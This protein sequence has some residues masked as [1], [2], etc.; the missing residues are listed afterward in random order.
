MYNSILDDLNENQVHIWYLRP[1]DFQPDASIERYHHLLTEQESQQH[2]LFHFEKDRHQYLLTRYLVRSVLSAYF[3]AILPSQ[4]RFSANNYG[5]PHIAAP[6]IPKLFNFNLSHTQNVIVCA[7]ATNGIVGV[8]VE[9]LRDERQ[10]M[11]LSER[12]YAPGEIYIINALPASERASAFYRLWTLKE[13]FIKAE[14]KGLSIEL[15][16]FHFTFNDRRII[17]NANPTLNV[18]ASRYHFWQS[19]FYCTSEKGCCEI[20]L[21]LNT[22]SPGIPPQVKLIHLNKPPYQAE[23]FAFS[24]STMPL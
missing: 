1:N 4:W 9:M 15:N 16:K 14:G 2:Q 10:L 21:A 22:Y 3:P 6:A 19:D 20:G 12:F 11:S 18:E 23:D 7:V 17:F 8:D 5:R 13:A 24:Y